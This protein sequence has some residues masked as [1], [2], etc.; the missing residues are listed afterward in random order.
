MRKRL[1]VIAVAFAISVG[2][3]G[4]FARTAADACGVSCGL[5]CG[6]RCEA[7]CTGCTVSQ[8]G[9]GAGTCCQELFDKEGSTPACP[10]N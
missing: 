1:T 3:W 5:A 8:C 7:T 9:A 2:I 6:N 4:A 10:A